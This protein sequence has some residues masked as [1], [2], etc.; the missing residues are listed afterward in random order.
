MATTEVP[1]SGSAAGGVVVPP[2]LAPGRR[3]VLHAV[4]RLEPAPVEEVAEALDMTES[5][6]RQHLQALHRAGLVSREEAPRRH[7]QRGRPLYEY[8]VTAAAEPLFPKAYGALTNELLGYLADEDPEIVDRVFRRR[9]AARIEAAER[10]LSSKR[11]LAAKVVELAR[12]LDEDG[13][14]TSVTTLGRG[15]HRIEEHNCAIASVAN[16]YGQACSSEIEFIRA[17][18]PGAE[19]TRTHHMASGDTLCGYDI[20]A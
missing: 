17:V 12:I 11:S 7:G 4:R 9:R 8:R 10:R 15:H 1:R 3:A 20:R 5:G 19:V 6:A 18:L 14:L 13:Y 16:R 2:P